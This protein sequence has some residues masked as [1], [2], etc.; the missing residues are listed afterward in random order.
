M[1]NTIIFVL[2]LV[3]RSANSA[4]HGIEITPEEDLVLERKLKIINKPPIKVIHTEYGYIVDCIDINKQPAFDHP[5]L[6]NHTLQ[7]KPSF[8]VPIEET[9]DS[10]IFGLDKDEC[11]T[12]TVPI[13]RTTK[14]DLIR[15]KS[16]NYSIM[17]DGGI[18]GLHRAEV[19]LS[20]QLGPYYAV[21]GWNSIYNPKVV[22]AYQASIAH[23]WVQNGR[24]NKFNV[25]SFGW[26]VDPQVNGDYATH[27]YAAWTMEVRGMHIG[28]FPAAI[29]SN[30]RGA[31]QVG[32]GGRTLTPRRTS[33]PPMGSGYFPDRNF[34]HASFFK[35]ISYQNETRISHGPEN[36]LIQYFA[37]KRS[38]FGLSYYGNL[39][40]FDGYSLQFGG[41]GGNCGD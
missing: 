15:E 41:P 40:G 7:R 29:F 3:L 13:R 5:L 33:S 11:P 34:F 23:I 37:D 35:M 14:E 27:L 30:L 16:L 12:G 9:H 19:A 32:W 4:V 39:G 38:C 18:I 17:N 21:H 36:Y 6:K 20:S 10:P 24:G 31:E 22:G 26:H 28:Y 8:H 1:M 2:C 25:I